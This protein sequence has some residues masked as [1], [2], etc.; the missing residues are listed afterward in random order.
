[1]IRHPA[2]A[3]VPRK[4]PAHVEHHHQSSHTHHAESAP[5]VVYR[6]GQVRRKPREQAPPCEHSEKI[7]QLKRE[8]MPGVRR[9]KNNREFRGSRTCYV[10]SGCPTSRVLC[11]KACPEPAE[12]W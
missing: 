8:G 11:E 7:E 10:F 12:G 5:A 6:Q 1:M 9:P 2:E 3:G 4:H